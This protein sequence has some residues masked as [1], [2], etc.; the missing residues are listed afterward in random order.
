[1]DYYT[2]YLWGGAVVFLYV[3]TIWT[4][5]L[6]KKDASIIDIFWGMGFVV[7]AFFYHLFGNSSWQANAIILLLVSV[8]GLRLSIYLASRNLGKP[9]DYRYQVWRKNHGKNWWWKSFYRVFMLQGVVMWI[10][11]APLLSA[12]YGVK[13]A[14]T[15]NIFA[16]LAIVFW[17]IGIAFEAGGDWQLTKFKKNP[18]NKGKVLDSGFWK[19][20]RHPNYFGDAM[21]WWAFYFLACANGGYACIASTLIMNFFLIRISGVALLEKNLVKTKPQYQDY[22]EKTNAFLPW[23]PKK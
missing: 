8:W 21:V 5:S 22:I 9:E 11:S 14:F 6:L 13:E 23:F 7:L 4:I 12:L 16:I 2:I 10:V 19:L 15:W 1:M 3:T 20:T 18:E 17:T